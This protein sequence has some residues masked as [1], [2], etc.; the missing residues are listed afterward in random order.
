MSGSRVASVSSTA[1]KSP[2]C[3]K[4]ATHRSARLGSSSVART[5]QSPK[6]TVAPGRAAGG[7]GRL[8]PPVPV[9]PPPAEEQQTGG[10]RLAAPVQPVV[11]HAGVVHHQQVAGGK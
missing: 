8:P 9:P 11:E 5:A 10:P 1:A 6:T 4:R 7:G 2:G 3:S